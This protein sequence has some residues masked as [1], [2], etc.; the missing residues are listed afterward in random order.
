MKVVTILVALLVGCA[1]EVVDDVE[2]P[3]SLELGAGSWRF[4]PLADGEELELIRGAQGGWHVWISL[5]TRGLGDDP[6]VTLSLQPEDESREPSVTHVRP[7]LDPEDDE[8]YRDLVGHTQI[9]DEPSCMVG[10]MMH[11]EASVEVDGEVLRSDRYFVVLGG[12]F[13]P[14]SCE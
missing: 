6:V 5:R 11:L 2:H 3:A 13:P 14:P 4:E 10:E 8:G 9:I 7:N 1:T 12:A